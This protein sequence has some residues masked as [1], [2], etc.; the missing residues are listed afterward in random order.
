MI[1][2]DIS[3][4]RPVLAAV[5]SILIVVFGLAA[6]LGIPVRELP[7][8]DTAVVTVTTTYAGA[9]PEI[10]DTDITET[11]EGA[12]AGIS[13]V[14]SISS[15]SRRGRSR[16]TIEFVIG[17]NID[18]AANDVRSAVARVRGQLPDDVDEPQVVKND[19][20]ADPVIR[21]AVTSSRMSGA[22][23]TDYLDRFL[24]DRL[25]TLDGVANVEIFGERRYAIR[26]WLDR[27]A[28]AARNLT[29]ADVES[30]IKR[31]NL[32]LPA[33]D[34]ESRNR[35]LAV[36]IDSR[37]TN[38][39]AFSNMVVDRVAGYPVRLRDVAQ[40]ALGVADDN[41]LVRS[42]GAEA[43]GLG[44][45]RQ[46]QANTIA[47]SRAVQAELER[48]RPTLPEGMQITV[49]SDDAVFIGA[50]IREVL[51]ALGISLVLVV[52]VILLF[53]L[54][55]RATLVPAV[56]IPVSL[57]GCFIL[58]SALGFSIN[59]L[60]L[61][62]LILAI[63]LVVDDAIVVLENI[64]RRI[65]EGE[66]PM[67][68]SFLGS[69]QVTFAVLATSLTLIAV[70]VPISFLKGQAGRLFTEFG[71]VMASAVAISTFVALTLCPVLA[72]RLLKRHRGTGEDGKPARRSRFREA[73]GALLRRSLDM[74]LVVL[75]VAL[76]I[77]GGGIAL[78]QEL[79]RELTPSEDRGIVFIPLTTPQG[80]TTGYTDSEVRILEKELQPLLESGDADTIYSIVGSGGRPYR[81]FVIVRLAPWEER[82][83]SQTEVQRAII[84]AVGKVIGARGFPVTPSGLGLRGNR[85][86][87]SVVIGGP[88]FDSVK[89][90]ANA[91][92]EKAKENPG[93]R[94]P[95]VDFE[96]NQ[97][98]VDIRLDREKLD[99][100]DISVETVASTLQ[101][102]LASREVSTY[103]DR[104]R[105]YPVIVQAQAS[106]R[107]Q[108]SDI[109]NI[110]VRS[111]DGQTLVPLVALT[112]LSERAA[113]PELNRYDR[114]PSITLQAALSDGYDLG[115]AIDYIREAAAETLPPE[116]SI[117]FS[118]QSQQYLET[119]GGVAVT[120]GL[121]I[122]IVFLVLAAQ[123]ESFVHPLVI[124]LSVPLAFAGAIYSL[125]FA[126]LSLNIYSQI[127]IIL[128][129]GL[130]AKNGILIV[131]FANQLRDE[132][133]EVR[134]A[135][136]E[137]SIL[138][139]RPIIMTVISTILGAVPLV[140]ASGAGAE[141]R[142][143]IGVVIIGGLAL[144]SLLT[145][146]V[147]PVLYD[148]LARFTEPRGAVEKRLEAELPS[149]S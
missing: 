32:E 67:V 39:D 94:N 50:S 49:G 74:P 132:G 115:S 55:I 54:S 119:S 19:A 23:I 146:V 44:I 75:F 111:G 38:V 48:I 8:V 147:T 64:Q 122:L 58:I 22:Q 116:A 14:K 128:L 28:L 13:G 108:P 62:A 106:D 88:D 71:F 110:F 91:L 135:V 129:V 82:S 105:E 34:V 141:S 3:I 117:A 124:M 83:R 41:T 5:A 138:R 137:A 97:P 89:E 70:F 61:L 6:L 42:N 46:S 148:L 118:G 79:P 93:L 123:F 84:P 130:M 26:I 40:V 131:E 87:L 27:E 104:G 7:D 99:D 9:A 21:L 56:T 136:I 63:G 10:V 144:A 96:E 24:V 107:S 98:Q 121:A 25:A 149:R 30:A 143:A 37:L 33:G 90:W 47:I 2:S 95:E 18:E 86:P 103:V 101:T 92:L 66:S 11:I 139:F 126:G 78:Y 20:D 31:N 35:L 80:S 69:R 51:I 53:L 133:K 120:F 52:L 100:L 68:A 142:S 145:L 113:A 12:V 81:A 112:R 59:V 127:G 114:L 109:G 17:R 134:E 29:V 36:R 125:Y 72:S 65:D 45:S 1:L 102:M 76:V 140:L 73:Y 77:A 57:I 16:T 85:T 15:Q 60:T 4:K 43:V